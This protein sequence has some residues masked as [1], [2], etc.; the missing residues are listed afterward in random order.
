M[1]WLSLTDDR[2]LATTAQAIERDVP[3]FLDELT[4]AHRTHLADV[5][6]GLSWVVHEEELPVATVR[7]TTLR[8]D[9]TSDG[10]PA[11]G[12]GEAV[13]RAG[14]DGADTLAVLDVT[15]AFGARGRGVGHAVLA[16]L[17]ARRREQELARTLVLLRP[18]RKADYPL[19]PFDRYVSF[20][21]DDGAPVD[22][23][24]RSAWRLGYCPVRGVQRSLQA[25]ADVASWERWL[26]LAV[27]GSGPYLV[28]GAIKP[29]VIEVERDEGRY[30]EPHLWAGASGQPRPPDGEDWIAALAAAGVIAGERSHREVR[31]VR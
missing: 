8:W 25:H 16:E 28:D 19:I 10:A 3:V 7:A 11:A 4:R 23:W 13:A 20:V 31:R 30:R 26:G 14:E 5:A 15:V 29:V 18:H 9:G 1:R 22:P 17:D 21:A 6:P 27:P 24:L 2:E 12:A